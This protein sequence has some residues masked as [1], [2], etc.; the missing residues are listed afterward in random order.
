M[1]VDGFWS[2][3]TAGERRLSNFML[4]QLAY[5]EII[6]SGKWRD[7]EPHLYWD[8]L[9]L[10]HEFAGVLRLICAY[11]VLLPVALVTGTLWPDFGRVELEAALEDYSRRERRYGGIA[12]NCTSP[13]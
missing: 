1:F 13:S 9:R 8:A 4:W 12:A 6:F 10:I 2:S 11:A 3:W 7:R 5:S